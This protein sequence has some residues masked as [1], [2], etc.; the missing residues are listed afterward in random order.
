MIVLDPAP[1]SS[2]DPSADPE[3]KNTTRIGFDLTMP[4]QKYGKAFGKVA[5][6]KVD[7]N[8]YIK[9]L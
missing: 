1:G 2:L 4:L 6:P 7:I 5:F 9:D 8:H 3:T